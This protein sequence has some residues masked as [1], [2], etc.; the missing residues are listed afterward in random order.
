MKCVG[1]DIAALF[2]S[3]SDKPFSLDILSKLTGEMLLWL[4]PLTLVLFGVHFA[5]I[6]HHT[7][8]AYAGGAKAAKAAVKEEKSTDL[9]AAPHSEPVGFL[10]KELRQNRKGIFT[11]ILLPFLIL[12]FL[13][14]CLAVVSL[15]EDYGGDG[16]IVRTLTSDIFRIIAIAIGFF[17]VSGLLLSVFHGDD[18]KLWAYFLASAPM[19][20][21]RFLYTKY[22][23]SFAMCGMYFV[24]SYVAETLLATISRLALGKEIA[25]FS[26]ISVMIFF[27][28]ILQN[29]FSIPMM[30]RFGEKKGSIIN[31]IIILCL[32]AAAILVLSLIP[33]AIQDK[34][35]AWLSAFMTGDNGGLTALLL[36]SFPAFSVGA[37]ILSYKLS[38]KIF[39]K[40]VNEYDK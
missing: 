35:S 19:G 26:S 37:Y 4:I 8:C 25:G 33:A 14:G 18:K 1:F 23:L 15:N 30:L 31:L 24:S 17:S 7:Q 11:V 10:Y 28:L 27:A 29:S 40:G 9:A 2:N 21:E 22:V 32:A 20:A 16:W 36:G 12:I 34:V 38:C 3:D 5:V 6:Y 13:T 39:M